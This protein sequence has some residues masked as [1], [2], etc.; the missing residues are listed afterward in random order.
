MSE[1]I[2][3]MCETSLHYLQSIQTLQPVDRIKLTENSQNKPK[4]N[5]NVY[6]CII[7]YQMKI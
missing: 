5:K 1:N 3:I 6:N 2:S 4:Q 7:N